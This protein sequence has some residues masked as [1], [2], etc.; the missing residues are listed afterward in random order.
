MWT[1]PASGVTSF[2]FFSS[3]GKRSGKWHAA[4]GSWLH[5]L[6]LTYFSG[7]VKE[8]GI[9]YHE[10][11]QNYETGNEQFLDSYI[12]NQFHWLHW[13]GCISANFIKYHRRHWP[14]CWECDRKVNLVGQ[15]KSKYVALMHMHFQV[16]VL[17]VDEWS[18]T[19]IPVGVTKR[20]FTARFL[21]YFVDVYIHCVSKN[22]PL[23]Q[24]PISLWNID[25]F[26]KFF[27]CH[28]LWTVCN[29]VINK[30]PTTP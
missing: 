1:L 30:Y 5:N 27:H 4:Q 6:V 10:I 3:K 12:S 17:D 16:Y 19:Y 23:C 8:D 28:I 14:G 18:V 13:W 15:W 9:N 21:S 11:H 20:Y 7:S 25:R 22:T 2:P 24:W 26:S 29:K